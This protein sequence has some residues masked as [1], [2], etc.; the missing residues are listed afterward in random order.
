M[1]F[2]I[3]LIGVFLFKIYTFMQ[4]KSY[5]QNV[6]DKPRFFVDNLCF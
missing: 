5:P 6:V 1:N 2:Y 3:V 4:Q